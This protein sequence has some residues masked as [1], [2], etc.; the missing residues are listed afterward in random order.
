MDATIAAAQSTAD[1]KAKHF[2]GTANPTTPYVQGRDLWTNGTDLFECDVTRLTGTYVANDFVKATGYDNTQTVIDGGM[3]TSG[4]VQLAGDASTILAGIT[5][6][7]TAATSVRIW[8]GASFANRA[9][10]SFRVLQSGDVFS[11]GAYQVQ[12]QNNV[13]NAGFSGEGTA[14][15]SVRIWGGATYENRATAPFRVLQDGTV[16]ATTMQLGSSGQGW[17]IGNVGNMTCFVGGS[18]ADAYLVMDDR[19]R[20][21]GYKNSAKIGTQVWSSASGIRGTAAFETSESNAYGYNIATYSKAVNGLYNFSFYAPNGKA[22]APSFMAH[23]QYIHALADGVPNVMVLENGN[24]VQL[25]NVSGVTKAFFLPSM[26]KIREALNISSGY[27][28]VELKISMMAESTGDA[29]IFPY[30]GNTLYGNQGESISSYAFA[31]G[32]YV[33][34]LAYSSYSDPNVLCYQILTHAQ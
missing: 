13:T 8:S 4:T 28:C 10:A 3:V 19:L 6:Q 29:N 1:S 30:A 32:D 26:E 12:N 21:G 23:G 2:Y 22:V 14:A 15:T 25:R 18:L 27:I 20:S 31:K 5:G 9:T 11:K 17:N 24:T 16:V 7:G 34:I 33:S